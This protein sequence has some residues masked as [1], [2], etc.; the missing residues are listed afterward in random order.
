MALGDSKIKMFVNNPELWGSF[1]EEVDTRI[2]FCHK[3]LE[4]M[5]DTT[6]IHRIQGE[7]RA[8]RS[9]K[10]LRDKVNGS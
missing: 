10:M 2:A 4:Q 7:I 5:D 6:A 9:M 3:Q 1:V 8:L